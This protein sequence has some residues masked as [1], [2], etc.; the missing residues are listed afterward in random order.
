MRKAICFAVFIALL[1][2]IAAP[3][4]EKVSKPGQYS[5][6]AKEIYDGWA[7]SSQYVTV[8]DGTKIAVDL[9]RPTLH[10]QVSTERYP[11]LWIQTQYRRS[12]SDKNGKVTFGGDYAYASKRPDGSIIPGTGLAN[13]TKYGYVVAIADARGTGASFGW[14]QGMYDESEALDGYDISE[15]LAAQSFSDGNV[16]MAGCSYLG[17]IQDAISATTPPHLKAFFP[18]CA[19]PDNFNLGNRGGISGGAHKPPPGDPAWVQDFHFTLPVDGDADKTQLVQAAVQHEKNITE[20]TVWGSV[21]LRDSVSPIAPAPG[22]KPFGK[23]WLNTSAFTS[24]QNTNKAGMA[25]YGWDNWKD[26]ARTGA[27]ARFRN[28]N[29]HPKLFI[30]PWGHCQ[31]SGELNGRQTSFDMV[32]EQHRFFDRWLKGIDNGLADEPPIYY[33]TVN[34]PRDREWRFTPQWPLPGNRNVDYYLGMATG[35]GSLRPSAPQ[36]ASDK[37]D[38]TVA[39][40]VT[41]KNID[42]KGLTYT[43]EPFAADTEI[44]GHPLVHLWVSSTAADADV[45]LNLEDVDAN[46]KSEVVSDQKLRAS[47]RSL[48]DPPFDNG[49][50]PW[51]RSYQEDVQKLVPGTPV[52][53]VMDMLPISRVMQAG[54]RLRLAITCAAPGADFLKPAAGYQIGIWRDV[55][56][57]SFVTLPF[58]V[59]P[60]AFEGTAK[61]TIAGKEYNGPADLFISPQTAYL[62]VGAKWLK[63]TSVQAVHTEQTVSVYT[64][65]TGTLKVTTKKDAAKVVGKGFAFEGTA[66]Y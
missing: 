15:W 46:G 40:D 11:V 31:A 64:G 36:A 24:F 29:T 30:G 27:L 19:D 57:K 5:G 42:E 21:P 58:H 48:N 39:Y 49:G 13:L 59:R 17:G 65:A 12:F 32:A 2:T 28:L 10:G 7:R 18:G 14:R 56:H 35:K 25:V 66:K 22:M 45:F 20:A 43:S 44:T 38:Y 41:A 6:Y 51:H 60:Y 8:R 16:G 54:H 26:S 61:V 23:V 52:E 63:W 34:A 50:L 4:Q 37:D 9:Y 1:A 33:A 53:M 62:N 3:A 55:A 47:L